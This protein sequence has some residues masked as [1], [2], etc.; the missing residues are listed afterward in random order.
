MV[1]FSPGDSSRKDQII[2]SIRRTPFFTTGQTIGSF[3]IVGPV[4]AW[5]PRLGTIAPLEFDI[6]YGPTGDPGDA[7]IEFHLVLVDIDNLPL[8]AGAR[9]R[10]VWQEAQNWRVIVGGDSTIQTLS[11]SQVEFWNP[12]VYGTTELADFTQRLAL[13]ITADD[14]TSTAVVILGVLT[15]R[16]TL[17]QRIWKNDNWTDDGQSGSMA[18]DFGEDWGMDANDSE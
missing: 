15:Y 9:A 11:K 17:V 6:T 16:E 3:E 5:L 14:T 13:A 12:R 7:F 4:L 10:A 8:V 18:E 2:V 1:E